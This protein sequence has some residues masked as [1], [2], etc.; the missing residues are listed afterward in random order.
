MAAGLHLL[1]MLPG[2]ADDVLLAG[3]VAAA[4]VL[5]HPL[6]W[7]RRRAGPPGLVIGY[8]AHSPDRLAD[9]AA[10]IGRAL[11]PGSVGDSGGTGEGVASVVED[12]DEVDKPFQRAG[13]HDRQPVAPV[14]SRVGAGQRLIQPAAC[15]LV[16]VR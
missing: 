7:H 12:G 2:P 6:S 9:A 4:G 8:A 3:R 13:G 15:R 14:V 16:E 11:T 1:V 5:V 10:R